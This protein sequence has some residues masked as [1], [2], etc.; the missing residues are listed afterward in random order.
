MEIRFNKIV[1]KKIGAFKPTEF[2]AKGI[3]P[4]D[5]LIKCH[6]GDVTLMT[7]EKIKQLISW[8]TRG[9]Y[10]IKPTG[11]LLKAAKHKHKLQK[12]YYD[13]RIATEKK[14]EEDKQ[15]SDKIQQMISNASGTSTVVALFINVESKN[16]LKVSDI[17]LIKGHELLKLGIRYDHRKDNKD[18]HGTAG[19]ALFI[20]LVKIPGLA[21]KQIINTYSGMLNKEFGRYN[22]CKDIQDTGYHPDDNKFKSD[23]TTVIF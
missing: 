7:E 9:V 17:P 2:K 8:N 6:S 18:S 10:Y 23:M 15:H 22:Y 11:E 13:L 19:K 14:L 12:Q 5:Y 21:S 1:A 3:K 4:G 16:N 20:A